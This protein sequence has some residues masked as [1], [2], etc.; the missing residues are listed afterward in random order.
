MKPQRFRL[1]VEELESRDLPSMSVFP[2]VIS[3]P[4]A[5]GIKN[6]SLVGPSLTTVN[7][8]IPA[9]TTSTDLL[10]GIEVSPG[11]IFGNT[12][13]GA[14]FVGTATGDLP[15]FWAVSINY[16]PPHPGPGVTNN[17]VGGRWSLAVYNQGVFQGLLFGQVGSGTVTWDSTG[18]VAAISDNNLTILGGTGAFS[19]ATGTGTFAGTLSHSTFPP[20]ISG[21]LT[22]SH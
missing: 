18:T 15:G 12:R 2:Q 3:F 22:L 6:G 14:T 5:E 8:V 13:Y 9:V 20:T 10:S 19:G 7:N 4:V 1:Q 11:I 16:S 17:I 21:T